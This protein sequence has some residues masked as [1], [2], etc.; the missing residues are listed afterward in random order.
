MDRQIFP[1][2]QEQLGAN[3]FGLWLFLIAL[4]ILFAAALLAML[5]IRL[6]TT[7]WPDDLPPLPAMLW[8]STGVLLASGATIQAAVWMQ[9]RQRT[10]CVARLLVMGLALPVAFLVLQTLAWFDWVSAFNEVSR[11]DEVH[12]MAQTGFLVLTGLHGAHI[13]GGLIPLALVVWYAVV[14][15]VSTTALHSVSIYWHFLDV[16]WI[17]LVLFMVLAL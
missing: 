11:T 10:R 4:A 17:V 15:G 2:N 9:H 6:E 8:W 1:T 12:R 7:D 13:I 5:A 3:R 14:R 16:V